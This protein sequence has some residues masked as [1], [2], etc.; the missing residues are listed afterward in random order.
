MLSSM[1][2]DPPF[3]RI[4]LRN[5]ANK[6]QTTKQSENITSLAEVNVFYEQ[7]SKSK[8]L[9]VQQQ[10]SLSQVQV[11]VHNCSMHQQQN[12]KFSYRWQTARRIC[13]N[14]MKWLT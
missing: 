12:K 13:A 4:F 2:H 6:Q 14:A 5:P 9:Q 8:R 1:A 10:P 3:Y 11:Q 7:T